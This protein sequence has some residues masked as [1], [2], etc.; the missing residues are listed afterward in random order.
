MINFDL[1]LQMLKYSKA[2]VFR[3]GITMIVKAKRGKD[4]RNEEVIT[5]R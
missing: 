5:K 4:T 2:R 1:P 3:L